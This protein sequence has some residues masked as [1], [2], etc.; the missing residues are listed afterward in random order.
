[1]EVEPI[2]IGRVIKIRLRYTINVKACF[3][4][5]PRFSFPLVEVTDYNRI[6]THRTLRNAGGKFIPFVRV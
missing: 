3:S 4:D 5:T 6:A 2:I 1:M